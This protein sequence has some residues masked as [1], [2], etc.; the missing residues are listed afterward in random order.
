MLDLPRLDGAD[1]CDRSFAER[2]VEGGAGR[3]QTQMAG[4][5]LVLLVASDVAKVRVD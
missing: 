3:A 4:D 1:P 5:R 2:R